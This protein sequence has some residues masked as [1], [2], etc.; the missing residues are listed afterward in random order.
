MPGSAITRGALVAADAG[1]RL[2]RWGAAGGSVA[3]AALAVLLFQSILWPAHVP[4]L[5]KLGIVAVA[6][7]SVARPANGLL[8][9]AGLS[10]LAYMLATRVAGAYPARIAEAIAL[11][12]LAGYAVRAGWQRFGRRGVRPSPSPRL[13]A[14]VVVFGAAAIASCIVHYHFMQVWQDRPWPFLERLATFLVR[15]YHEDLGNYVPTA[16]DAGFRFVYATA[17]VI[18]GAALL[19]ASFLLC[20]RDPTLLPRLVRMIVV[21]AAGAGTLS[22]YAL[23]SAALS[24]ADALEALGTLLLSQRWTMFT[25]KLNTAS[26]LFVLA[27]ALAVGAAAADPGRRRPGWIAAAAILAGALLINGTRAALLAATLVLVVTAVQLLRRRGGWQSLGT[28]VAVGLAVLGLALGLTAFN[29]LYLH[30]ETAR[31]GLGIRFMYAESAIRMFASSPLFGVGIDQYYLNSRPFASEALLAINQRAPAHN[32]FLHH[33]GELGLAGVVP[34]VWMI[35]AALRMCVAAVRAGARDSY[36]LGALGGLT[37]FLITSLSAGHALLIEATAYPFW[38]VLGLAA[39]RAHSLAPAAPPAAAHP[40]TRSDEGARASGAP[41]WRRHCVVACTALLAISLP[42][43][44][45]AQASNI[46]FTK[47]AYG[48]HDLEDNGRE[49]YRWTTE[50]VTMFLDGTAESVELPLRAPLVELTGPMTVEIFLDERLANRIEL[51]ARA[52]RRVHMQL[53]PSDR[54]YRTLDLTIAPTWYPATLL[55]GSTD[56]RELG[57]MVGEM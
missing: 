21:G 3:L 14:P 32:P 12:F 31:A 24:E 10:P 33:A 20:I 25:P 48:L 44:I 30:Q 18:E 56:P 43:R 4:W 39:A 5:L 51:T 1:D 9:V 47:I 19:L 46:D 15:G 38:I 34:F 40:E 26:T 22:F 54:R 50:H 2:Y 55:P 8:I 36:L 13:L 6:L 57:V 7:V 41:A 16:G 29:W 52:W 42:P 27:G 49:R 17:F 11:A 35:G 23:A 45:A 37:A 28:P 53:P